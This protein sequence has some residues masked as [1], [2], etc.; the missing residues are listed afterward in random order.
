MTGCC[1]D[2]EGVE[3]N[4]SMTGAASHVFFEPTCTHVRPLPQWRVAQL[5]PSRAAD[6]ESASLDSESASFTAAL[7]PI[8]ANA[9]RTANPAARN[10]RSAG[11]DRVVFIGVALALLTPRK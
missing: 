4:D 6:V 5:C 9:P 3:K 1:P 11:E 7:H 8:V 10:Q 2:A